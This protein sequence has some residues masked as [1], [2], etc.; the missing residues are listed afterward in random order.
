MV[1]LLDNSFDLKI[2]T[3]QLEE[4]NSSAGKMDT[5][6]T[7]TTS[8][9]DKNPNKKRSFYDRMDNRDSEYNYME[10]GNK[11]KN[12]Y[13]SDDGSRK[14]GRPDDYGWD[15]TGPRVP[16]DNKRNGPYEMNEKRPR[17]PYVGKP[18]SHDEYQ[19]DRNEHYYNSERGNRGNEDRDLR[20]RNSFSNDMDVNNNEDRRMT[21]MHYGPQNFRRQDDFNPSRYDVPPPMDYAMSSNFEVGNQEFCKPDKAI[22]INLKSDCPLSKSGRSKFHKYMLS[23]KPH[24]NTDHPDHIFPNHYYPSD[25]SD[26]SFYFI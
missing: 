4:K 21:S 6:I 3:Q 26:P 8:E 25:E 10:Y 9:D 2:P 14:F 13:G 22:I 17:D 1:Q 20:F 11:R 23:S 5:Q 7:E 18:R 15:K 12:D 19:W 24:L 16:Y